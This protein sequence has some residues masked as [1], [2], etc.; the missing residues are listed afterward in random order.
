M[1][2]GFMDIHLADNV[3]GCGENGNWCNSLHG[4]SWSVH[5]TMIDDIDVLS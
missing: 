1:S 5:F 4:A 2:M 3:M